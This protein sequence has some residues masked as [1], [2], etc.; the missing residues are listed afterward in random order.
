SIAAKDL[1]EHDDAAHVRGR[2]GEKENENGA[3]AQAFDSQRGRHGYG[4][5]S[6]S[7]KRD[8]Q[9]EHQ[10]HR[11]DSATPH[12][13]KQLRWNCDDGDSGQNDTKNEPP[14]HVVEQLDEAVTDDAPY[15]IN[16]GLAGA[17]VRQRI[18]PLD[19]VVIVPVRVI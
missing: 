7:V 11:G 2:P 8:A 6:A 9:D 3:W 16:Y 15:R 10:H 19:I 1:T 12:P 4:A 14:A 5:G 13:V 18:R 17:T